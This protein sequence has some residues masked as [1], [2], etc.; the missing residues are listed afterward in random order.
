[1]QYPFY[2]VDAFANRPYEGNP[3]GVCFVEEFPTDEEMR[4]PVQEMS[5]SEIAYLSPE[6]AGFRIRWFTPKEEVDLCGHA[7][8][9]SAHVL[10][11]TGRVSGDSIEFASHS[12]PLQALRGQDSVVLDFPLVLGDPVA[13]PSQLARIAPGIIASFA[14]SR[15]LVVELESESAVRSFDPAISPD[16]YAPHQ[17]LCVTALSDDPKFDFV[18][19]FFAAR[20]G[21]VEDPA[22]GS[23]HCTLGPYWAAKLGKMRLQARQLSARGATV[24][25]DLASKP[26][27]V[28]LEGSAVT[29]FA[30]ELRL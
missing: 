16:A 27:R 12:G 24:G 7:T 3:A 6:R 17:D 5:L 18:S 29:L 23:V 22:T 10:W 4:L 9:A 25:I 14:S 2:W 1:M 19:R 15:D 21:I 30:G 20:F 8:L 26:G 28:C 13:T 11:E